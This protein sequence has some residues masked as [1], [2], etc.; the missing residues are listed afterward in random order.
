M[1]KF[2]NLDKTMKRNKIKQKLQKKISKKIN[3]FFKP[4]DTLELKVDPTITD[5]KSD[6]IR[7]LNKFKIPNELPLPPPAGSTLAKT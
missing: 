7:K 5:R 2:L 4:F 1:K 3:L 6:D